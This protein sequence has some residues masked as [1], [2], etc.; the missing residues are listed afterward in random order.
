MHAIP[1]NFFEIL[2]G[3]ELSELINI[4]FALLLS[5]LRIGSFLISSP[6]LGYRIIPVQV[7]VICSFA[8]VL[9]IFSHVQIPNINEIA[10]ISLFLTIAIEIMI[11]LS[12]GTILTILFSSATVAG[13]KI[14]MSSGLSF[15]GL[16]DPESGGQTPV[17]S[18]IMSL[19]VIIIFL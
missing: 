10:G 1:G 4:L 18:Q 8:L 19:F 3:L 11:G 12:A 14:A 9:V 7:R 16:I 2:P 13:E 6:L 15:A 17:L 5:S